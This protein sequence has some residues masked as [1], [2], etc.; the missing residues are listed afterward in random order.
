LAIQETVAG[1]PVTPIVAWQKGKQKKELKVPGED[2]YY[3]KTT[4]DL[5]AYKTAFTGLHP[6][7]DDPL[8][9]EVDDTAVI[10]AGV[11]KPHGRYRILNAVLTPTTSLTRVRATSTSSS[12]A[13]PPRPWPGG[14]SQS[15]FDVSFFSFSSSF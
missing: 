9:E 11:G 2:P 5:N 3:G 1:A 8:Q 12:P 15:T 14:S 13:I 7:T 10:V 6:E 4:Q